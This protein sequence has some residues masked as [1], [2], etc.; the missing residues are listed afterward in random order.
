M[1][2]CKGT[3]STIS[4]WPALS[5]YQGKQSSS[6]VN[7]KCSQIYL[8][9]SLKVRLHIRMEIGK[10]SL[11]VCD[12]NL[13]WSEWK[14]SKSG[15]SKPWIFFIGIFYWKKGIYTRTFLSF[16]IKLPHSC[17]NAKWSWY[18][19]MNGIKPQYLTTESW[20]TRRITCTGSQKNFWIE[21]FAR[22]F[23]AIININGKWNFKL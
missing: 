4:P 12:R 8:K 18:Q 19:W 15:L 17:G 3:L 10:L 5:V 23:S 14:Y 11:V 13:I 1:R 2:V 16:N 6:Q 20:I 22:C 9:R 7:L 21:T